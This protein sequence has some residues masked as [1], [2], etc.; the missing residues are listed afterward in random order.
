MQ[1]APFVIACLCTGVAQGTLLK[2]IANTFITRTWAYLESQVESVLASLPKWLA[3]LVA[4]FG[5]ELP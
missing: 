5:M 3:D 4:Q 1:R 2:G